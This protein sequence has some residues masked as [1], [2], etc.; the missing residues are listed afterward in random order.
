MVGPDDLE[1]VEAAPAVEPAPVAQPT[2]REAAIATVAD[3]LASGVKTYAARKAELDAWT[4]EARVAYL[5]EIRGSKATT[6]NKPATRNQFSWFIL[7]EEQAKG[8][9]G[10]NLNKRAYHPRVSKTPRNVAVAAAAK[11]ASAVQVAHAAFEALGATFPPDTLEALKAPAGIAVGVFPALESCAQAF[12][13]A[14]AVPEV[15]PEVVRAPKAGSPR[16]ARTR[17]AR[18]GPGVTVTVAEA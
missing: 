7:R 10:P 14:A 15:A 4:H 17:P 2:T 1:E 8:L 16:L 5:L 9:V 12:A 11:F 6:L 3:H 13:E 18:G